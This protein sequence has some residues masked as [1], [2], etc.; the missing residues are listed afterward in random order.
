M[1]LE[2]RRAA[3]Q[4]EKIV[5]RKLADDVV[6]RLVEIIETGEFSQDDTL[7]SERDLMSRFGVGRPAIREALQQLQ[8]LGLIEISQGQRP[9]VRHPT[10]FEVVSQIDQAAKHTQADALERMGYQ[11]ESSAW[12]A[13]TAS[14]TYPRRIRVSGMGLPDGWRTP[15]AASVC[16]KAAPEK[17]KAL[18]PLLR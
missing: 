11:A 2:D 12:C 14:C 10:V 8:H 3:D 18:T 6:A 15:N 1:A 16:F 4:T 5:K 17:F 9:T 7:P 13:S